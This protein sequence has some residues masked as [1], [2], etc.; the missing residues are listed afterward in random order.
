MAGRFALVFNANRVL[1]AGGAVVTPRALH[2]YPNPASAQNGVQVTGAVVGT[3][4]TLLDATG[5]AV[6]T[7]SADATGAA[8]V[9]TRGLAAGVYVLRAADGRTTRLVVE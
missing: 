2:L 8:T 1:S 9:P 3:R 6:A 4:L 7:V 5:R